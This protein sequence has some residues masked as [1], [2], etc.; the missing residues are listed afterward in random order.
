MKQF[1]IAIIATIITSLIIVSCAF[2]M[3][4]QAESNP[5]TSED[6]YGKLVVVKSSTQLEISTW[7]VECKDK[8][9]NL[10]YFLNDTGDLHRGDV[11]T[12]LMFRLN[13]NKEDDECM[14]YMYEGHTD[15][16]ETFF[17]VM[18]WR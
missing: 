18:G 6:Y 13:E 7:V 8:D 10:W 1:R 11:L 4:A 17:D 12:L 14:E 15:N 9:G 5:I 16:L 2:A 3:P